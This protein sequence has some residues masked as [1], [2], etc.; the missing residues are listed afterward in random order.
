MAY[1]IDR[2]DNTI[3]VTIPDG[4]LDTTTD[5]KLIGKNFAGYGEIQNENFLYLLENFSGVVEPARPI[6]GQLWYDSGN[7]KIKF[8]D[9]TKF[10]AASGAEVGPV[11]PTGQVRGDL[12]WNSSSEE[13]YVYNGT[14]YKAIGP[15]FA[16]FEN[17]KFEPVTLFDTQSVQHTVIQ[18][19]VDNKVTFLISNDEFAINTS[20]PVTGFARVKKGIT[21]VNTNEFGLSSDNYLY[22]GTTS[23][24]LRLGG[25]EAND[26]VTKGSPS[27]NGTVRFA[28]SGFSVG[29]S[30]DLA[31]FIENDNQAVLQNTIGNSN[32]I[33]IKCNN[34]TGNAVHS[35]SFTAN[36]IE[37]ATNSLFNLGTNSNRWQNLYGVNADLFGLF[38]AE[39]ATTLGSTLT[40]TGGTSLNNS[41]TVTGATALSSTLSVTGTA[42]LSSAL[43]VDGIATLN[44]SIFLG[45]STAD[46]VVFGA[47]VNSSV[48]PNTNAAFNL[49]STTKRW[50]TVFATTFNGVATSAQYADLAEIYA[51]DKQYEFGTVVKLGGSAEVTE[52]DEWSDLDVFGVVSQNPAYLMN[53]QAEG[54]PVALAGRV[55]VKVVGKVSKGQR[56]VSSSVPGHAEAVTADYDLEAVIGRSLE[57]KTDDGYGIVEAVVGVK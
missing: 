47:E 37:P 39:G 35:M 49:G 16:G 8:Y 9:G 2:Y 54:V 15:L 20:T 17:T 22:W 23:N 7:G 27:F 12:W 4:T 24:A 50:N 32:Q 19:V 44:G 31:V 53:S 38:S 51:S 40:V 21:L 52:T 57:D 6:S 10:R 41:L 18:A 36:G 34:S 56:L 48:I 5:I 13:L 42:T 26:Y 29:D 55:P 33:K 25:V 45:N 46:S 3:L 43:T 1:Q 30:N 11:Q 28:D 14:Q